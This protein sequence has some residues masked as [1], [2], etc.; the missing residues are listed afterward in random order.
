MEYEDFEDRVERMLRERPGPD[1][2]LRTSKTWLYLHRRDLELPPHGWK[3]HV[4]SRA[5]TF[6]ALV[7]RL[8][9]VLLDA[10]CSFKLAR[11]ALVL[12]RLNNG[13]SSPATV[14]KAFTIYP[15]QDGIRALGLEL[16]ELLDGWQGP[17]VLSDRTVAPDAPVYYRYGPFTRSWG[18]DEK[19]RLITV[20][21]GPNPGDEEFGALATMRYRQP[22]WTVDPFTGR[23]GTDTDAD[24]DAGTGTGTD[25]VT[26]ADADTRTDADAST[27]PEAGAERVGG[28]FR[29]V[30]GVF[31]SGRGNVYRAVD[32]R[33]GT[34]VIV[35]QARALVD[36]TDAS[37]D[38]RLRVRNE[39]RILQALAGLD[40]IAHFVDHFRHGPDEFL[41][42]AD[43]GPYNLSQDI[44][45]NGRYAPAGSPAAA[46]GAQSLDLLARR[47]ARVLLAVHDRG[48]IMRDL[49]PRNVV[50][51]GDR[52]AL[53][54]FGLAHYRDLHLPGATPGYAP[55]RQFQG[56]APSDVDDLFGLGMT[57]LYAESNV[58]PVTL[59]DDLARPADQA[60]AYLHRRYGSQPTGVMGAIADLLSLDDR[61]RA[62][63]RRLAAGEPEADTST[64]APQPPLAKV[65]RDS[66]PLLE[67]Q[68]SL[69]HDL[70]D[71][72]YRSITAPPSSSI[73]HDASIYNGAAGAGLELLHHLDRPGVRERVGQLARFAVRVVDEMQ[74][75]HGYLA[76]RT[77]V[78]VFLAAA[79]AAGIDIGD[80][81]AGPVLPGPDWQPV[82]ADL[83]IGAAG[84]GLGHLILRDLGGGPEHLD[85]ADRCARTICDGSVVGRREED[86]GLP[87]QAAVETS[88]GRA[89]GLAGTVE[90]LLYYA[91][92]IRDEEIL[93]ALADRAEQLRKRAESLLDRLLT[94]YSAPIAA[95]WCQG[96]AGINQ[97]L[98]HAADMLAEPEF[99]LLARRI[100]DGC[101]SFLPHVSVTAQCCGLAGIGNTLIDVAVR[102]GDEHSWAAA[103]DAAS[104]LLLR[105]AGTPTRPLLVADSPED[106]SAS[107]AFGNAGILAFFRRL[108]D[109]G[110]AWS[111]PMPA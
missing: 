63:A 87:P 96:M 57:L 74:L 8:L 98:L 83:M 6:A 25:A 28:H 12:T 104:F 31:E 89:H 107:W 60:L 90:F 102:D 40:G 32:E 66:L 18:T 110:G 64:V 101:V 95:S 54:D 30:E 75:P 81:Y 59:G 9:P 106:G 48:V 62:A 67:I 111:L 88:A 70:L 39:R 37:G 52:V 76:G 5:A 27:N 108:G 65:G 15:P 7:E 22:S 103:S 86:D 13:H 69:L 26:G 1:H 105:G 79:T 55:A 71:Q 56:E 29:L 4:S 93:A 77:G 20:I 100:A 11:S 10:R 58:N 61:A 53:I 85:V 34:N 92:R 47:L 43:A 84:V 3:L 91:E 42:T 72:S 49:T 24:T 16:A 21:H 35:K 80:D 99:A 44:T 17:R 14:G 82:G 68:D 38:V 109:R 97:T 36:E 19:A 78:D 73:A 41:V 45:L 94:P 33:D 50:V 51:T 23:S 2:D 46:R